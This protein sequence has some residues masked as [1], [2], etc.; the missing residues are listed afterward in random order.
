MKEDIDIP[1][2]GDVAVAIVQ[3]VGDDKT[4]VYNVYL[5]NQRDEDLEKVLVIR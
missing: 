4:L 1:K 2:V 3:E 5:I